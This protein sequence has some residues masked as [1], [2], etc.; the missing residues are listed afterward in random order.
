MNK[1]DK[2]KFLIESCTSH[3]PNQIEIFT[4]LNQPVK[5]IP[6]DLCEV[7][8]AELHDTTCSATGG[9]GWDTVD[10]GESKCSSWVQSKQCSKCKTKNVFFQKQCVKCGSKSFNSIPRDGRWGISSSSHFKYYDT[11]REYRL[12]LVEP[13]TD[14]PS[15][16]KFRIRNWIIDKDSE[17]LN[18]YA[19]AQLASKKS[20]HINFQPLKVDFY[21]S[22][23]KLVFELTLEVLKT[24]TKVKFKEFN[25][26]NK[27]PE[28]IPDIFK[29]KKSADVI[30]KK[31]FGKKRGD[32]KR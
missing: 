3:L 26:D 21:L 27:E 24:K 23:P 16:R 22:K 14:S 17:H 6:D 10:K 11:L 15:C 13:L 5:I 25:L 30:S 9:S 1:K 18:N 8:H 20:N 28:K 4:R 7:I 19:S 31:A 29:D 12:M 2:I 32:V